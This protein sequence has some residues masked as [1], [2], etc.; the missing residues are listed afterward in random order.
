MLIEVKVKVSRVI[1][2]KARWI[3]ETYLVDKEFFSQAEYAV[4]EHLNFEESEG[5]VEDFVIQSLK[6]ST[7]K[8][9]ADQFQGDNKF[10]ATLK[11]TFVTDDGVEKYIR[12]K[13]LLWANDLAQANDNV[14]QL[15]RQGYEMQ[16]EGI[17]QVNYFIINTTIEDE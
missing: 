16:V 14:I 10:I 1:D 11:D 13:V 6:W 9:I 15:A 4:T 3:N 5:D 2:S 8:E 7:I 12:Y 17:K